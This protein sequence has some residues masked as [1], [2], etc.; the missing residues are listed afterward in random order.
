MDWHSRFEM[1]HCLH[2]DSDRS[3]HNKGRWWTA[4]PFKSWFRSSSYKIL[5]SC[6]NVMFQQ[7]FQSIKKSH[8]SASKTSPKS[9]L[10]GKSGAAKKQSSRVSLDPDL[11]EIPADY[12]S[13]RKC[14]ESSTEISTSTMSSEATL[15][16]R[17]YDV[18]SPDNVSALQLGSRTSF[19]DTK[20]SS[21]RG[22]VQYVNEDQMSENVSVHQLRR[23]TSFRDTKSSS[24][25]GSIQYGN[26]DLIPPSMLSLAST[27]VPIAIQPHS[28][29]LGKSAKRALS[30]RSKHSLKSVPSLASLN[31]E[32]WSSSS[33]ESESESDQDQSDVDSEAPVAQSFPELLFSRRVSLKTEQLDTFTSRSMEFQPESSSL[34]PSRTPATSSR[35]TQNSLASYRRIQA[36]KMNYESSKATQVLGLQPNARPT[37]SHHSCR[38]QFS[39]NELENYLNEFITKERTRSR[40]NVMT[41]KEIKQARENANVVETSTIY[42]KNERQKTLYSPTGLPEATTGKVNQ[43]HILNEIGSGSFGRVH[44]CRHGKTGQYYACKVISK[45]RLQK[46]L[47]WMSLMPNADGKFD[48]T[49]KI[50]REI[51]VLKKL[52]RHPN[53][54]FMVE[55]LDDAKEDNIYMSKFPLFSNLPLI[56]MQQ[57]SSCV[58]TAPSWSSKWEKQWHLTTRQWLNLFWETFCWA[59]S[60]VRLIWGLQPIF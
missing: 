22:S 29:T 40:S 20:S 58:N 23:R 17:S 43:Y 3:P 44:L 51:A 12:V 15:T 16:V 18:L 36:L 26:E 39:A 13:K 53:I 46:K 41:A 28:V 37:T 50:K 48:I 7:F 31:S 38:P 52:S 35:Q 11:G 6:I 8:S 56:F 42:V 1:R 4:R 2:G 27:A 47:R 32:L 14:S 24:R 60:T 55:V 25:R 9:A 34:N 30:V 33:S 21:R 49:D 5:N 57:F 59:W 19:R 45:S 10:K 54:N